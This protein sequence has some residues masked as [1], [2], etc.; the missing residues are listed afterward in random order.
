MKKLFPILL[1]VALFSTACQLGGGQGEPTPI[2]LAP[3]GSAATPVP[4]NPTAESASADTEAGTERVSSADGM[5]Q[6][7]IPEGSFQMGGVDQAAGA[8][9]K[10]AHQVNMRAFWMDKIEVTNAMYADCVQSGG[11]TLPYAFKTETRQS[12]FNEPD[13]ADFPVVYVGWGQADAY[14]KW[15][16]RRLPTEAEWERAARGDDFRVYPWGTDRPTA[17]YANFNYYFG[18]TNRVGSY[19]DGASPYG[20]FDMAGNVSEWVQDF[21]DGNYYSSAINNNP[22][23]PAARNNYFNRVVRGGSYADSEAY[24]RVSKRSSVLGPNFDAKLDSPEYIG[25]NASRIGFRCASNN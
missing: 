11:C 10:P 15:A 13:F 16:G 1:A 2:A 24:I 18:D 4:L 17:S 8:D 7:F 6:V 9:E 5:I 20:V 3:A 14:C 21:Y 23:G 19:P 12:Y 25:T 22:P